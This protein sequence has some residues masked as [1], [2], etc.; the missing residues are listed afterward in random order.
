MLTKE[1]QINY[2]T[3]TGNDSW[4]SAEYLLSGKR[5]VAA[6]FMFCLAIEK[7]LKAIWVKDNV[8]NQT[9]RIHDLQALYSERIWI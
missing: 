8:S 3:K 1:E 2:W 5:K 4:Q 6:L 9:P 7:W